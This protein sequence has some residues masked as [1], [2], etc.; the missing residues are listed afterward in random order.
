MKGAF[1]VAKD[2][3]IFDTAKRVLLS[4]GG[5]VS[6]DGA[7]V[8]FRDEAGGLFTIYRVTPEF[9][10][11]FKAGAM[12]SASGVKIPDVGT[13]KGIAIECRGEFQFATL[14]NAIAKSSDEDMWVIDG[15]G[16]VWPALAVD[17]ER[18][19]L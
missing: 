10:W 8:Q 2:E 18:I 13:L 19:R 17:P 7:V 16:V 14:V 4:L 6:A 5:Q 15:D 1:L 3:R 9:E 11:E 12:K